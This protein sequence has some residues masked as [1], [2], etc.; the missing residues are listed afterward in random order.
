M[1]SRILDVAAANLL[2]EEED[3]NPAFAIVRW[4][5]VLKSINAF[6]AY[7]RQG[8]LGVNGPDVLDYLLH[9][10]DFPRSM[11]HCLRAIGVCLSTLPNPRTPRR[12]LN[13]LIKSLEAVNTRRIRRSG[14]H[15]FVDEFQIGIGDIHES[16]TYAYFR[17]R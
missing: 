13:L 1:S 8:Y 10:L 9:E 3:F 15:R 6:Q 14:L 11:G 17:S 7:R 12:S 5:S 2:S 4:I 16:L